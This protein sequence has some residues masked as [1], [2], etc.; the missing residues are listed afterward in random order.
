MLVPLTA[1]C[2]TA[3]AYAYQIPQN[4][5]YAILATEG[6][7]VG[8]AV[9]NRNGTKD[10]GPFQINSRWAPAIAR[11]LHLSVEEA[12]A[13]VRDDGCANAIVATA[14]LRS[15]S[16][17]TGGDFTAAVGLYH[18]HSPHLAEEYRE[19]ALAALGVLDRHR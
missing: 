4:Y 19:K 13:R 7:K 3:A 10:L 5:L 16:N 6:G 1:A 17:E 9:A 12:V 8:Q 15:C 18:S 2:L 11:Y 14:I